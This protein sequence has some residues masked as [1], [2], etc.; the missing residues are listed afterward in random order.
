MSTSDVLDLSRSRSDDSEAEPIEEEVDDE[1]DDDP[2][3]SDP[4]QRRLIHDHNHSDSDNNGNGRMDPDSDHEKNGIKKERMEA[5]P[6][7]K[8][9]TTSCWRPIIHS[10]ITDLKLSNG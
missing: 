10:M 9:K 5:I 7:T 2:Y 3:D 8:P 4:Y 6:L 1:D